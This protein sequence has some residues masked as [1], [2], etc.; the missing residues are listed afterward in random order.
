MKRDLELI[1]DILLFLENDKSPF[2]W[3]TGIKGTEDRVKYFYHIKIL[4]QAGFIESIDMSSK[5]DPDW[6][7]ISLTWQGHEFL[8]AAKNDNAWK[9]IKDI[10]K[11]EGGAMPF[12]LLKELLLGF[13]KSE[14]NL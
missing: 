11:K 1:R 12:V 14:F 10:S 5:S 8:D 9:K 6:A 4:T 13:I 2:D 7:P 3:K